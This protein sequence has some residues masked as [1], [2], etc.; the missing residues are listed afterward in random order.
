MSF[1]SSAVP[2]KAMSNTISRNEARYSGGNCM[3]TK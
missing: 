1:S 3:P 2:T